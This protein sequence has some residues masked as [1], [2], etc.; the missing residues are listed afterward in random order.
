MSGGE[1]TWLKPACYENDWTLGSMIEWA[2]EN[3]CRRS[4]VK[5]RVG[6]IREKTFALSLTKNGRPQEAQ[7]SDRMRRIDVLTALGAPSLG[8]DW[9]FG[10]RAT[11]FRLPAPPRAISTMSRVA[12]ARACGHW[13]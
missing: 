4:V 11:P 12:G 8:R 7:S 9:L 13:G 3:G 6:D 2:Y 1:W 10:A 5:L